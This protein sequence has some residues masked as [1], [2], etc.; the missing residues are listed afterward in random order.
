MS[1]SL[2][3]TAKLH[4][5]VKAL[6]LHAAQG[7]EILN[8]ILQVRPNV[9]NHPAH[10]KHDV[11]SFANLLEI[12][13]QVKQQIRKQN[14]TP[15]TLQSPGERVR[16]VSFSDR[17]IKGQFV[18]LDFPGVVLDI[19]GGLVFLCFVCSNLKTTTVYR[20]S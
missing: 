13:F 19:E 7:H 8:L 6:T 3:N 20:V 1:E 2:V 18:K 10:S 15:T 4:L 14:E 5:T 11:I 12:F 16:E 9:L 17:N